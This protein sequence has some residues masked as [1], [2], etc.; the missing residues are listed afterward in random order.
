ML[1][2]RTL[3]S[4][5][6]ATGVG[7]HTGAPVEMTLRPAGP[8]T[9]IVFQRT[10]L[11]GRPWLEADASRVTDTRMC[12]SL[13]EGDFKVATVEHLMSALAGT[14]IDNLRIELTGPE[15]PILDGS[16]A[17]FV[18]LIQS[19]GIEELPAPKRFLRIL[20]TVEVSDGDK[21][22][23]LE[24]YE[25]FR[26]SFSI[27]FDHPAID[28]TGQS[29]SFDLGETPYRK[30]IA[31]ARTFGFA[32]EVEAMRSHGLALG[33]SLDNAVVM[34]EFR[35]LNADGLRYADEFVK[36]KVLDAIG[37]LYMT[38]LPL[39]GSFSAHKS[40]HELNNRL[41]RAVLADETAFERVSFG[42][43]DPVPRAVTR[44]FALA[45]A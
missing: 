31:R 9:G 37:D 3:K 45:A 33:G 29:V 44:Q 34:D 28:R 4:A 24:P 5:V 23:R 39:L 41:L 14:G 16:A 30:D 19:T 35:V 40:G 11:P 6:T 13:R 38:G 36:H 10:D 26:L 15:V 12:T 1:R 18:F 42:D 32:H 7:L 21:W 22:A 43:A 8:D 25:G 17:P 20:R 2:Q 27:A